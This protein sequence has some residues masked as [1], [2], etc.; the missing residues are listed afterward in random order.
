MIERQL[1]QLLSLAR[2]QPLLALLGARDPAT[3]RRN[4]RELLAAD[5]SARMIAIGADANGVLAEA[6]AM[7]L[8][9]EEWGGPIFAWSLI[10][11]A[12][13]HVD[14]LPPSISRA[15]A[16]TIAHAARMYDQAHSAKSAL[17]SM[18]T[19]EWEIA[20][21]AE[22]TTV[23]PDLESVI[24]DAADLIRVI[25]FVRAWSPVEQTL[26]EEDVSAALKWARDKGK[27]LG[28]DPLDVVFP[29]LIDDQPG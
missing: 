29:R 1:V 3:E 4:L 13:R 24:A 16:E 20:V 23:W 15:A 17:K 21:L 22:P 8:L 2:A 18:D 26:S 14:D 9:R 11:P 7:D 25:T 28:M 12:A 19:D 27:A 6:A 10:L 5:P